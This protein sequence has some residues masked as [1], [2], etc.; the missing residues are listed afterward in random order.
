MPFLNLG[1]WI[2]GGGGR[3]GRR[4][5]G[6]WGGERESRVDGQKS[7]SKLDQKLTRDDESP[8]GLAKNRAPP[9]RPRSPK[10]A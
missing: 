9:R 4:E 1:E 7:C 10:K 2:L 3:E 5:R 6:E 8:T